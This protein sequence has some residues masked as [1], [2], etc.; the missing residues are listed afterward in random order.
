[1]KRWDRGRGGGLAKV[2]QSVKGRI[3]IL[4]HW[5]SPQPCFFLQNWKLGLSLWPSGLCQRRVA[6]S[7]VLGAEPPSRA[8][9]RCYEKLMTIYR[10]FHFHKG[11]RGEFQGNKETDVKPIRKGTVHIL[12]PRFLTSLNLAWPPGHK[13]Q[14][15]K[16]F[17][18]N[19][20]WENS[21]TDTS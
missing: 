15:H 12:T 18:R 2:S 4:Q 10:P 16:S 8:L 19:W 21:G 1:M 9:Q 6:L 20:M 17:Q 7:S 5:I 3:D 14:R 11:S 13:T